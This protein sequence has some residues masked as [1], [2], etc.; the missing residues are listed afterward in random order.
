[1]Q[2][3]DILVHKTSFDSLRE[4]VKKFMDDF[5]KKNP[6]NPGC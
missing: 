5:H 3:D 4:T 1:M 6:L 2:F